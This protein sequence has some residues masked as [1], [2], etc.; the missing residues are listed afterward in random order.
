M[1]LD[2]AGNSR[3]WIIEFFSIKAVESIIKNPICSIPTV[4]ALGLIVRWCQVHRNHLSRIRCWR[5]GS[6]ILSLPKSSSC[7]GKIWASL[8][9]IEST[10]NPGL[11]HRRSK[12]R[13]NDSSISNHDWEDRTNLLYSE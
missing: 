6:I 2:D 10:S 13:R 11:Q 4:L 1:T 5:F 7:T 3:K 8:H 9:P 12:G